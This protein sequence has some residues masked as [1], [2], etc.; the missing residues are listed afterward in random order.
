MFT[1]QDGGIVYQRAGFHILPECPNTYREVIEESINRGW[2][3]P[4]AYMR[5]NELTFEILAGE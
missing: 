4:V 1:I 5:D 3:K 2:L